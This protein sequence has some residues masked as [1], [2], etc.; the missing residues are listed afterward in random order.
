[1]KPSKIVIEVTAEGEIIFLK[2]SDG[3]TLEYNVSVLT[4]DGVEESKKT[5]NVSE[6]KAAPDTLV[7]PDITRERHFIISNDKLHKERKRSVEEFLSPTTYVLSFPSCLPDHAAVTKFPTDCGWFFKLQDQPDTNGMRCNLNY[8]ECTSVARISHHREELAFTDDFFKCKLAGL[9]EACKGGDQQGISYPGVI[10]N[11]EHLTALELLP[12]ALEN[13]VLLKMFS[14]QEMDSL[15][16]SLNSG[17][18]SRALVY[19]STHKAGTHYYIVVHNRLPCWIS[20]QINKIVE[21]NALSYTYEDWARSEELAAAKLISKTAQEKILRRAADYLGVAICDEA[22]VCH[23]FTNVLKE[24]HVPKSSKKKCVSFASG[25]VF[26]DDW[27]RGCI[28]KVSSDWR[29]GLLHLKGPENGTLMGAAWQNRFGNLVPG[30]LHATKKT[31]DLL[32]NVQWDPSWGFQYLE[33]IGV[34]AA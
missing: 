8:A 10:H 12:Y 29:K 28:V 9:W 20:D 14:T 27:D 1:M 2:D 4:L 24:G 33:M 6:Q 5:E 11:K 18:D 13:D 16:A 26:S 23:T 3:R 17:G 22:E 7:N 19:K 32:K 15:D 25:C 31:L 21:F 34:E 30:C